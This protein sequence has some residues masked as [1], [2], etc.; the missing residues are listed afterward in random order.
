MARAA[1]DCGYADQ[2]HLAHDCLRLAR[3]TPTSLLQR[4]R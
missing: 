2:A 3:A 4:G 1:A